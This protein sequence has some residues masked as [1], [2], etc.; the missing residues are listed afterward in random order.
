MHELPDDLLIK[1]YHK[2]VDLNLNPQFIHLLE[3][4]IQK[5]SLS[6]ASHLKNRT[7]KKMSS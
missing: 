7:A 1:S 6:I 5:R 3:K 2:A 4:E